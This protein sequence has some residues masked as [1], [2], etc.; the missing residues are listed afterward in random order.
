MSDLHVTQEHGHSAHVLSAA[1]PLCGCA[2]HPRVDQLVS[3]AAGVK[4][5]DQ[6]GEER[7]ARAY[8]GVAICILRSFSSDEHT[9][10]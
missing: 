7:I 9:L 2:A 8:V 4:P 3:M 10:E 5:V 6:L 1:V